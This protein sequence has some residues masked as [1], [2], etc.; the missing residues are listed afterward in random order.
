ADFP[1]LADQKGLFIALSAILPLLDRGAADDSLEV[2]AF[3]TF[4]DTII[5]I[6]DHRREARRQEEEVHS[7]LF[8]FWPLF[9]TIFSFF[10]LAPPPRQ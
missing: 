9:L 7:L 2:R 10:F 5:A 6:E 8:P 4:A 1:V 3:F